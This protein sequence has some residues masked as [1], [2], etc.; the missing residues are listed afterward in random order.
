[1]AFSNKRLESE[2]WAGEGSRL[3]GTDSSAFLAGAFLW[4][5]GNVYMSYGHSGYVPGSRH[6]VWRV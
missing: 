2:F 3:A 1:M 4:L 6:C 5:F